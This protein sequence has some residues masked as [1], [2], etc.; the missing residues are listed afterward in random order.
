MSLAAR[1]L[2]VVLRPPTAT[3]GKS[4]PSTAPVA[5]PARVALLAVPRDARAAACAAA[6]S[7]AGGGIAVAAFW[8]ATGACPAPLGALPRAAR[9]AAA[10]RSLGFEATPAGRL[11]RVPILV[12]PEDLE[13]VAHELSRNTEHPLAFALAGIRC[14]AVDRLLDRCDRALV[15]SGMPC[16]AGLV[17]AAGADGPAIDTADVRMRLGAR[18]LAMLGYAAAPGALGRLRHELLG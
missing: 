3:E 11:V 5:P 10:L 4:E 1:L 14:A 6:L 8:G 13:A 15:V 17:E 7:I 12:G 18:T 2:G 16:V 9:H